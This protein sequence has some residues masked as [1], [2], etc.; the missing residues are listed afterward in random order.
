MGTQAAGGNGMTYAFP[1]PDEEWDAADFENWFL[2]WQPSDHR[3]SQAAVDPTQS[4]WTAY[5]DPTLAAELD[6]QLGQHIIPSFHRPAVINYLMNAPI[7]IN[8][9]ITDPT[10][11]NFFERN[12]A[13]LSGDTTAPNYDH[14]R[15]TALITRLR[16]ATMRPLNFEHLYFN[17]NLS[18]FNGDG[19]PYD[20]APGF[21]GSNPTPIL[22]EIIQTDPT[23]TFNNLKSQV[24]QLAIWLINGPWDVD[25]D[26]DGVPDSVWIDLNLAPVQAPDGRLIKPLIAMLVED[27]DG[28]INLNVA[29]CY[30]QMLTQNFQSTNRN[31][32]T[33]DAEYFDVLV[34][35]GTFGRGGGVGPAEIDFSH[36]FDEGTSPPPGYL[37]PVFRTQ[38]SNP[39][40]NVLLTRYG[41]LLNARY[42][43]QVFNYV[44]PYPAA[45]FTKFP[46]SNLTPLAITN[47]PNPPRPPQASPQPFVDELA[48]IPFPSRLEWHNAFAPMGQPIDIAGRAEIRKDRYGNQRFTKMDT[49]SQFPWGNEL[50]NTPYEPGIDGSRGDDTPFT[51]HEFHD[52]IDGGELAGRLSQLLGDAADRNEALRHLLTTESRSVDSPE[53]AGE[54]SILHMIASKVAAPGNLQAH[55]DRMLAVELRKGSK[56]NLN[57]PLGNG[58]N[59]NSPDNNVDE[60]FETESLLVSTPNTANNR[61]ARENVFPKI[62][63]EYANQA[64]AAARY[65]PTTLSAR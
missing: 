21:S 11:P 20:G 60:T 62:A 30:N 18:D 56:L 54:H 12:F 63:A 36:L 57:R 44:P 8:G 5:A 27:A 50:V 55:L 1:E 7:W 3:R 46:G 40:T 65:Q 4:V 49:L 19:I 31:G 59:D 32:Y 42:G 10:D 41:N 52:F 16:R 24:Q 29:G 38:T 61:R 14:L 22:S 34:S 45:A 58:I 9:D 17:A 28:K 43:G 53:V 33:N 51:P 15:L 25:N 39:I 2:A 23:V 37:G 26:N 64:T 13:Q 48:R 35:L 6:R 47:P